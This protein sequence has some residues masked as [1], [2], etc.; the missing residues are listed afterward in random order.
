MDDVE[1]ALSQALHQTGFPFEHFAFNAA[2]AQGWSARSNRLYVDPEEAKTRE[3][4]LLCYRYSKGKEVSIYTAVLISCKAR[5]GKPW[6]LLTRPWP[7]RKSSWYPYPPV[8]VWT[9]YGVLR[10]ELEKPDWGLSYFDLAD[11]TGLKKW[12]ADSPREVFALHEFERVQQ[13]GGR[14]NTQKSPQPLRFRPNGDSS[15]YEGTMSLLKALVYEARAVEQRR[16]SSKE[17]LVYQFNLVQLL[18]GDLY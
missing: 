15:L 4:D 9:N 7:D 3:M 13:Q 17:Q 5:T 14:T 8:A 6:V 18:D 2:Q 12:G 1:Q 16:G 11:A 10:H